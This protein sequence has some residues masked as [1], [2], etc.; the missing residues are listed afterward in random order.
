MMEDQ[1]SRKRRR[2]IWSCSQCRKQKLSCD[3]KQPVCGRCI[4]TGRPDKCLYV[5]EAPRKTVSA[6]APG[7]SEL[8]W[9]ARV[10][11]VRSSQEAPS[12]GTNSI[13]PRL[14]AVENGATKEA[15]RKP[16]DIHPTNKVVPEFGIDDRDAS[17]TLCVNRHNTIFRG[18]SFRTRFY[19]RTHS[20]CMVESIP[21]LLA[22]A[23]DAFKAF[24]VLDHVRRD[25]LSL[26][27][28][29]QYDHN[30]HSSVASL[31]L[32]ALLP[33]KD[34][35]DRLVQSYLDT[36][37][38]V[39]HVIHLPTFESE[40]AT[41]WQTEQEAG[42]QVVVTTLII[43]AIAKHLR[44]SATNGSDHTTK[45]A[46]T[47]AATILEAC[48]RWVQAR[49]SR[50]VTMNDFQ[51]GFL[52]LWA[53]QLHGRKCKRTWANAGRFLRICMCA[54]LH[55]DP[56]RL[57]ES[58]STVEMEMR[59]RIWAAA[60]EFELQAAF[61]HG[62]SPIPWTGQSDVSAPSNNSDDELR[63]PREVYTKSSYLA[64]AGESLSL[65]HRLGTLLNDIHH[66][67]DY[68]QARQV[69]EELQA[70]IRAIP[71]SSVRIHAL[72]SIQLYQYMLVVHEQQLK[73]RA[74]PMAVMTS[75]HVMI[76]AA[77]KVMDC[78]KAV[79]LKGDYIVELMMHDHVRA[80]LS[81]CLVYFVDPTADSILNAAIEEHA[82]SVVTDALQMVNEKVINSEGD[83]RHLWLIGVAQGLMKADKSAEKR[84]LFLKDAVDLLISAK[85]RIDE[86]PSKE[87]RLLP[88]TT[89]DEVP[90]PSSDANTAS[91]GA[92]D[93]FP[94]MDFADIPCTGD[95]E[96]WMFE[97]WGFDL[98]P[99]PF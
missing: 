50:F 33:K 31:D 39:Y 24:P 69:T 73:H 2:K 58:E 94:D 22:F 99:V 60:A 76:D 27:A 40:Y 49:S 19:G 85:Q 71:S 21:G 5:E 72:L 88:V 83:E 53:Q 44:V 98:A 16:L 47:E 46:R 42:I 86:A 61:E 74:S 15:Q 8:D 12:N 38:H 62:M 77:R 95:F 93:A 20:G 28:L 36:F 23:R 55:R 97:D 30:M 7:D 87:R 11:N 84:Q 96:N 78:H 18:S 25:A 90:G 64:I 63:R 14:G 54:G 52:L 4:K 17:Q 37:D 89:Q 75:R 91:N 34:E 48:E 1:P 51:I 26:N 57:A 32:R 10:P 3:R 43:I 29:A 82:M 41:L 81:A 35:T 70:H 79:V 66:E 65:R 13:L 6:S 80:A 68:D 67:N 9:L 92:H 56:S 45:P 59:R